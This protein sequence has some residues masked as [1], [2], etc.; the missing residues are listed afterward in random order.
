MNISIHNTLSAPLKKEWRE[1]WGKSPHSNIANSPEWF[2]AALQTYEYK[3]FRI[4]AA[5]RDNG[6]LV[7]VLPL[8]LEKRFG[9]GV[10]APPAAEFADHC[11]LLGNLNDK[12]IIKSVVSEMLTLGISYIKGLDENEAGIFASGG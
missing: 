6:E 4:I 3:C 1:L 10:F 12:S 11:A 5:N 9:I 7:A 2:E 8:V